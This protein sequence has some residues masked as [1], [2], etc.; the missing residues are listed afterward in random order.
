M[1][2]LDVSGSRGRHRSYASFRREGGGSLAKRCIAVPRHTLA[3]VMPVLV[4]EGIGG[5]GARG[6]AAGEL[7]SCELHR[8]VPT[9]T[10]EEGRRALPRLL[11][12]EVGG[13]AAAAAHAAC[14]LTLHELVRR[15]VGLP[16]AVN[17]AGELAHGRREQAGPSDWEVFERLAEFIARTVG[18][19]KG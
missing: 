9:A 18:E 6:G 12:E 3:V 7:G 10:A 5:A 14:G 13:A 17:V 2:A 11:G 19:L 16:D 1:V 4:D 8:G 15:V